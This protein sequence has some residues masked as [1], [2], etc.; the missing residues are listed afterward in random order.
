M[1][2]WGRCLSVSDHTCAAFLFAPVPVHN[3]TQMSERSV[4]TMPQSIG[5]E[6]SHNLDVKLYSKAA[7]KAKRRD[8][9]GIPPLRKKKD[10]TL[11]TTAKGTVDILNDR[12]VSVFKVEDPC[13]IPNLGRS[14]YPSLN[15]IQVTYIGVKKLLLKLNPKKAVGPALGRTQIL[16][17]YADEIAPMLQ[18]IFQQSLDV[19]DI[20]GTYYSNS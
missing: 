18:V 12:Y 15:W 4:N 14:P 5:F 10:G 2:E 6:P 20:A 16:R 11:E 19:T 3:T 13:Q 8:Q 17:D 7:R 9:V 1:D